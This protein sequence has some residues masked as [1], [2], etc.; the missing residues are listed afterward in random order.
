MVVPLAVAAW[1]VLGLAVAL[2][3]GAGTH[4]P[5]RPLPRRRYVSPGAAGPH[6]HDSGATRLTDRDDGRHAVD[7]RIT[8]PDGRGEHVLYVVERSRGRTP[9]R[10]LR[11]VTT[12]HRDR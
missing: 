6:P 1:L 7:R 2:L 4:A 11:L 3:V 12:G 10:P 8:G 9:A 5:R